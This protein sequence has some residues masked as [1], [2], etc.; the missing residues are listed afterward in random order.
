MIQPPPDLKYDINE[1]Q[2][3][4]DFDPTNPNH[5]TTEFINTYITARLVNYRRSEKEQGEY[6]W[7][8]FCE[9]FGQYGG[10]KRFSCDTWKL[11]HRT[12]LRNLREHLIS[13]GVWVRATG[14]DVS[15]AEA[16]QECLEWDEL[17]TESNL[18]TRL[19]IQLA[20]QQSM[21]LDQQLQVPLREDLSE[22]Q[23][24]QQLP[25]IQHT[26]TDQQQLIQLAQLST[27]SN[28]FHISRTTHI[29]DPG[30]KCK[31]NANSMHPEPDSQPNPAVSA[32]AMHIEV[33]K[34]M[35]RNFTSL[36][37]FPLVTRPASIC[38]GCQRA[39]ISRQFQ[40]YQ[41]LKVLPTRYSYVLDT[42]PR[43]QRLCHVEYHVQQRAH[44]ASSLPLLC[45]CP[46]D[47]HSSRILPSTSTFGDVV[48]RKIQTGI[49][50]QMKA[51]GSKR[52]RKSCQKNRIFTDFLGL[53]SGNF[54]AISFEY[55]E[56]LW[57]LSIATQASSASF[58]HC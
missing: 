38:S 44:N 15:C 20:K 40:L 45:L 7:E 35:P 52:I 12:A 11:A 4:Q 26:E 46:A 10:I 58:H 34:S 36:S 49:R 2:W 22:E 30:G 53:F 9:D 5:H 18:L 21:R 27:D 8:L 23:R 41:T 54:P 25:E 39:L 13:Q 42:L 14:R 16:L 17:P 3:C 33:I 47:P 1:N 6:L 51:K 55:P 24:I 32:S 43:S 37:V 29:W 50:I 48:V 28:T 57:P 19:N 56:A 31:T